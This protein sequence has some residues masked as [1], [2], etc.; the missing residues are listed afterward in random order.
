MPVLLNN[1]SLGGEMNKIKIELNLDD[2]GLESILQTILIKGLQAPAQMAALQAIEQQA[3]IE[4][5]TETSKTTIG[6]NS[7]VTNE[8]Q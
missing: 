6:F 1:Q 3:A 5:D 8:K 4:Q 2:K 7:G